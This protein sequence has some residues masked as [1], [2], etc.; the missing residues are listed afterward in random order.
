M[1]FLSLLVVSKTVAQVTVQ[2]QIEGLKL[3]HL[4]LGRYDAGEMYSVDS[5]G[6]DTLSG[7][8]QWSKPVLSAGL[9][10]VGT[11]QE[12]LFD[13][14][15]I[16]PKDAFMVKGRF[17]RLDSLTGVGSPENQ[18]FFEFERKRKAI[19]NRVASRR[20]RYEMIQR[21][22]RNDPEAL[23]PVREEIQK[24]V[25][26]I[27]ALGRTYQRQHPTHLYAR[28][29]RS[30]EPPDLP[31]KVRLSKD[32]QAALRWT[33]VHYFDHTNW[34]DSTLLCNNLWP[35][36]FDN[37]FNRLVSPHPDSILL[38]ADRVLKKMPK[39]GL[40]YQF[41]VVR[42]T[43]SF[44]QNE[45]PGSDRIF[46]HL[47]DHYQKKDD[48]PWLDEATLLRLEYKANTHRLNLTGNPAPA[49]TL[50]DETGV[51]LSLQD[52]QAPMTML[53]FYSP[54]CSHCMEVMPDIYQTW[55]AY[56]KTG[57]KAVAINTDDQYEHWKK[58][59][60]QQNWQWID[61]ADSTAK[62][63]FENDYAAFNLPVIYLLDKDKKIIRKR[64]KPEKLGETLGKLVKY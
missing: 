49:L 47:V 42:L 7:Q 33:Q 11:D 62:N 25:Q 29:L 55:L 5:V 43:R 8:F 21:A 30:I 34:Q 26:E 23:R 19:E 2:F 4:F 31:E 54:L 22:T 3:P 57:L 45:M 53:V 1:L 46:V 59:V 51:I 10:F 39:H 38:A 9:Y 64:V 60:G 37:Y 14:L 44:E 56:E 12:K 52:I 16:S 6:V 41:A 36:F 28:M 61:L 20:T 24:L 27:D 17:T 63:A 18:A 58:F 40:F 48:T 15:I 32:K 50:P 35:V 13:F